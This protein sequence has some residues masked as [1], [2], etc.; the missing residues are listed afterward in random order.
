MNEHFITTSTN[1]KRIY[2]RLTQGP[3]ASNVARNPHLLTL[4]KEVVSPLN[5]TLPAVTIEQDMGRNIGYSDQLE[6]KEKDIVFYARQTHSQ[7]YTR[8]VKHRKSD[9]TSFLTIKLQV[10]EDGNYELTNAW[11]G[12][13][14]PPIP[15]TPDATPSSKDYWLTHAVVFNG[16]PLLA[17][18][19]TKECPY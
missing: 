14:F 1:K 9:H 4:V 12:K 11:I 16:Q 13:L 3:L 18:T 6:T 10:D 15:G 17:S 8:F 19:V 2:G 7:E 5:L